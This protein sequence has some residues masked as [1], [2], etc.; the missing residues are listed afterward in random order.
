MAKNPEKSPRQRAVDDQKK[1]KSLEQRARNVVGSGTWGN[2]DAG[3]AY[4]R[5]GAKPGNANTAQ[6]EKIVQRGE[7]LVRSRRMGV[8]DIKK[9]QQNRRAEGEA[10][11]AALRRGGSRSEAAR[12]AWATRRA[13]GRGKA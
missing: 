2:N 3:D 13:R 1:R 7:S 9:D 12:K 6:L 4:R 5:A 10:R 8:A 11:S